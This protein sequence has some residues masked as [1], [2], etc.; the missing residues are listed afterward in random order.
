MLFFL[1]TEISFANEDSPYLEVLLERSLELKLHEDPYWHTI[2]HYQKGFFGGS[3]SL[4]DDP[5]FFN[6][7]TGKKNP[8]EELEAT[9]KS[10]FNPVGKNSN[11]HSQCRFIL[12][13]NWLSEK[14]SIDR[15]LL[16]LSPCT[17]FKRAIE[18]LNP[19]S[20]AIVFPTSYM[21]SPASMFGHTLLRIDSTDNSPLLSHSINYAAN[22]D[23][24][25]GFAFALRGLL[26]YYHGRYSH[27]P[28]YEK[29]NKY[30]GIKFRD[31][32]EYK[33]NLDE[34]EV[35][36]LLMHLIFTKRYTKCL[37]DSIYIR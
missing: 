27:A 13:Y 34:I 23:E 35:E 5:L 30:S 31:I 9:L 22:T 1:K 6:S 15:K 29:V 19:K 26:G 14:L 17:D 20:I 21:N 32:W 36:R 10:F 18:S 2:L 16:P 25:S 8:K 11:E 37:G 4:I 7:S 33:L 24:T 12:R 28:Y 3:E